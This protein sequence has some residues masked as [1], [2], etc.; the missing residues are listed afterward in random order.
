MHSLNRGCLG[1]S[2]S[3]YRKMRRRSLRQLNH[4]CVYCTL[5]CSCVG[6]V[7]P[8]SQHGRTPGAPKASGESNVGASIRP[9]PGCN[10]ELAALVRKQIEKL[11]PR[12]VVDLK[13]V[14]RNPCVAH[15]VRFFPLPM[16][17]SP[18]ELKQLWANGLRD[19]LEASVGGFEGLGRRSFAVPPEPRPSLDDEER[20]A[21]G[22]W[23]CQHG[24][25]ECDRSLSYRRRAEAS[26]ARSAQNSRDVVQTLERLSS[27]RDPCAHARDEFAD[28]KPTMFEAWVS[29]TIRG[30]PRVGRYARVRLRG[31]ERGWLVLRG[32][33]GHYSFA[34]GLYA[35]DL[36][37]GAAYVVQSES[38][39][40][41]DSTGGVDF[42]K[43]DA[44]RRVKAFAGSVVRDQAREL[45]F[46]PVT[47][48]AVKPVRMEPYA[49]DVPKHID[50]ELSS[51][52][53]ARL[54]TARPPPR[55]QLSGQ[56]RIAFSLWDGGTV[57]ASG[58]FA[59]AAS[60]DRALDRHAEELTK[61]LE[62]GFAPGCVPARTP[63]ALLL[64]FRDGDSTS[65]IDAEP[66]RQEAVYRHL[67]EVFDR[68]ASETPTCPA[69][70]GTAQKIGA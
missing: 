49:A 13:E 40:V 38:G 25:P 2:D 67:S 23:L 29:C 15:F 4:W 36:A 9:L 42:S 7:P 39:L 61:V 37:T 31:P 50:L 26:F 30:A 10:Q 8:D 19:C 33:R 34:D 5:L 70:P 66:L 28:P 53:S 46:V 35:Y 21:L 58:H 64:R 63:S 18:P 3:V 55:S 14:W 32:R 41:F 65:T 56:T 16:G 57:L 51:V 60:S 22:R 54:L 48:S 12:S 59:W 44:R 43:T 6:V 11:Q 24:E 47:A 45:A 1:R 69:E 17:L 27:E 62:A 20:L 52:P 68:L